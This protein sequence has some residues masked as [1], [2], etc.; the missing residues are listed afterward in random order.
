MKQGILLQQSQNCLFM[1]I[2]VTI[3]VL[4]QFKFNCNYDYICSDSSPFV[5]LLGFY[6]CFCFSQQDLKHSCD[7]L[8]QLLFRL[9]FTPTEVYSVEECDMVVC[10]TKPGQNNIDAALKNIPG[11]CITWLELVME[12]YIYIY[13]SMN[14]LLCIRIT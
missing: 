11:K 4:I 13:I 8:R 1:F 10:L 6:F 14:C 5:F 3:S 7:S 12:Q 2:Q 9:R